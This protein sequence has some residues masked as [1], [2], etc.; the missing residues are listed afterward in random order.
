MFIFIRNSDNSIIETA[1]NVG[2]QSN[3]NY[4]LDPTGEPD[5]GRSAIPQNIGIDMYEVAEIPEGV[6]VE[7]YCYTE[8]NG[9]YENPNYV[10]PEP[11]VEEKTRLLANDITDI[12]LALAELGE[13]IGGME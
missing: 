11:P 2:R 4:L 10:E 6:E 13:L 9:F 8:A 7:K 1:R 5:M 12:Q 3:G